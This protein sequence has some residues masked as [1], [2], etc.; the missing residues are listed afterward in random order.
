MG[1]IARW[2]GAVVVLLL[3]A[4][5]P[6]AAE[7][8]EYGF[9]GA[10]RTFTVPVGVTSL[11]M[12]AI[13]GAGG[14]TIDSHGNVAGHGGAPARVTGTIAVTPGQVLYVEVGGIG[15]SEALGGFNGGGYPLGGG[16][17]DVRTA[18][19]VDPY[20]VF[21]RLIVAGGGGGGSGGGTY[22]FSEPGGNADG[23]PSAA[24]YN[25][26]PG[27]A[28]QG[29]AGGT[30]A[31]AAYQGEPGGVG[32]G[33]DAGMG[34]DAVLPGGGGGGLW[35][36]GGRGYTADL[37]IGGGG[38]GSSL[39]PAGGTDQLVDRT[40]APVIRIS[41]T[42]PAASGAAGSPPSSPTTDSAKPS[43]TKLGLSKSTIETGAHLK[44]TFHLDE[45][46]RV[47]LAIDR[48]RKGHRHSGTCASHGTGKECTRYVR[49]GSIIRALAEGTD[50]VTFDGRLHGKRLP[51]GKYRLVVTARNDAG[52]RSK[53]ATH[54]FTIVA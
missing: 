5:T 3:C 15:L 29:G 14:S 10:E 19:R 23:T 25:G 34:A 53:A 24:G 38:G 54:T 32:Q 31:S 12:E 39:V 22:Q 28:T 33:G 44:V 27:T 20:S 18:S 13:G 36:G 17:S 1:L 46:A 35:G 40:T 6:A 30:G 43:V 7:T 26:K 11:Q 50:T 16:A 51:A 42:P 37:R 8:I 2:G 21:S 45:D 4:A 52:E 47:T 48:V 9:T 49:L 41:Y